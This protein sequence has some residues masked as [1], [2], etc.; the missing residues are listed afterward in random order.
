MTDRTTD[1]P[2][3]PLFPER[4]SPR[5]FDPRPIEDNMLFSLFEAAR[6]APSSMNL[7]PWRFVYAKRNDAYWEDFLSALTESNRAWA[8]NASALL[9]VLS[10]IEMEQRGQRS[11]SHTHSFDSGAAWMALALQAS[12]MGL[13]THGMAGVDFD[14]ARKVTGAPAGFRI[15]A[16]V[17]VGYRGDKAALPEALQVREVPSG[18][19]AVSE[20]VFHGPMGR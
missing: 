15:E 8:K 6:W 19:R 9:Y 18:R 10:E 7:Q 5:A 4:W 16:A 14:H 3:L 12:S 11:V 17:A 13:A 1:Y 2:V 20:S